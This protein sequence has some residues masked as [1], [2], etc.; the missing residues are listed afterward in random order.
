MAG[1][2]FYADYGGA[3]LLVSGSVASVTG[4]GGETVVA[5][6]TSTGIAVLCDI[7]SSPLLPYGPIVVR[8]AEVERRDAGVVLDGCQV[9]G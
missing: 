4:Q 8:S 6:A 3:T 7:G 9:V 5:L 2:R 1:D